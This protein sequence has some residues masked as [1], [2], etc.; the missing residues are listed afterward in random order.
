MSDGHRRGNRRRS[1]SRISLDD[2][3]LLPIGI[4]IWAV[5]VLPGAFFMLKHTAETLFGTAA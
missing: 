5:L 2:N 1:P 4:V 3:L